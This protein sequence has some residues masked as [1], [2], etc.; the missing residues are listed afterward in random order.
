MMKPEDYTLFSGGVKG[1]EAEFGANAERLGMEEVHFT[2]E[3]HKIVRKRG[4]RFLT[5]DE[6]KHGDVSLAYVSK[7]M[8]RKFSDAPLFRKILQSIWHMI[9]HAGEVFVVGHILEDK[10][11]KGGTGWG[12]E[13]AKLFNK[14]LYVYD[15][16]EE[17]WFKWT[18]D[19]W[20]KAT[21]KI[22]DKNFAG[23]GTRFL[24]DAGKKAISELFDRS[25]SK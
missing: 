12:A 2:F 6:L 4:I 1:A 9:N 19:S 18:G 14:P 7:L 25:F 15:Q 23:T 21:P 5:Q 22:R 10:T 16:D 3:G 17:Q 11:V 13:L 20:K 8:N 24:N